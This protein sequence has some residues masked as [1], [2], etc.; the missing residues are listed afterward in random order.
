[1]LSW[2]WRDA[3]LRPTYE[4]GKGFVL[5]LDERKTIDFGRK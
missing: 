1:M 2:Y 4:L 3:M 5:A